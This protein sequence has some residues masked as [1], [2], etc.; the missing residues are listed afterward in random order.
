MIDILTEQYELLGLQAAVI[1]GS[2]EQESFMSLVT[3]VVFPPHPLMLVTSP[4]V[5]KEPE[6]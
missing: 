2:N 6:N 1:A 3:P 5:K 4:A